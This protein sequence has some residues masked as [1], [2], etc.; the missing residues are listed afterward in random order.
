MHW[1]FSSRKPSHVQKSPQGAPMMFETNRLNY[2]QGHTITSWLHLAHLGPFLR[3]CHW[4]LVCILG[5]LVFNTVFGPRCWKPNAILQTP[6]DVDH[7]TSHHFCAN[8]I[9]YSRAFWAASH[10]TPFS[11]SGVESPMY[12]TTHW[13][14]WTTSPRTTFAQMPLVT[15]V[16]SWQPRIQHRF[17]KSVL[18]AQ[19]N[20]PDTGISEKP[21]LQPF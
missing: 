13:N 19:C 14:M 4:L 2:G 1:L 3:K 21:H 17:R 6:E 12:S 20:P 7:L 9:G 18:K 16:H 5:S 10:S 15:R 8:A 11:D